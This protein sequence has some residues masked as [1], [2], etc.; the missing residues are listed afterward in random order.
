MRTKL[1]S[2]IGRLSNLRRWAALHPK[3]AIATGATTV[4]LVL[5]W[6]V[7]DNSDAL[8]PEQIREI[9]QF[10]QRTQS[11]VVVGALDRFLDDDRLT[12]NETKSLIEIAKKADPGYGFISDQK[13]SE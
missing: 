5:A 6:A 3:R 4:I 9:R 13:I 8:A 12:V 10:A 7:I 2:A 1:T 11:P